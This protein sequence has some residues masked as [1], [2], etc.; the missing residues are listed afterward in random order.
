MLQKCSS[1]VSRVKAIYKKVAEA[2]KELIGALRSTVNKAIRVAL[3]D[4]HRVNRAFDL[5]GLMY[6]VWS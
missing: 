2:T 6:P 5:L 4:H 1:P 3:A